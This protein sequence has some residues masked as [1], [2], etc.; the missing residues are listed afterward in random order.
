MAVRT[1]YDIDYD[2]AVLAVIVILQAAIDDLQADV[3]DLTTNLAI[4]D[5]LVDAIKAVTEAEG[6][7][8]ETGGTITSVLGSEITVYRNNTP[9]G[10]F[11]PKIVRISMGNQTA[12]E[13]VTI[14]EYYRNVDGGGLEL[15]DWKT[16]IGAVTAEGINVRLEPN[17]FGVEVTLLLDAGT[18]RDYRWEGLYEV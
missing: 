17:R 13:T 1:H 11:S 12:T 10:V 2:A 14:K 8:E 6:V 3:D 4:V 9:A 5:A 16:Y 15:Y 7:L 18:P